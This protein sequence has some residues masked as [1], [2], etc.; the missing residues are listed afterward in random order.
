M[1]LQRITSP[2]Q[3]RKGVNP[4]AQ[5]QRQPAQ[6]NSSTNTIPPFGLVRVLKTTTDGQLLVD[7][8]NQD[9]QNVY[10]NGP[11]AILPNN[12]QGQGGG[13]VVTKATPLWAA[14][15]PSSGTPTPGASWGAKAGSYLLASGRSGFVILG[16]PV[17]DGKTYWRVLVDSVSNSTAAFVTVSASTPSTIY[18]G[19]S[20]KDAVLVAGSNV[21]QSATGGFTS[22]DV[23]ATLVSGP[24]GAPDGVIPTG[25]TI[26]SID[27][28]VTPPVAV[29]NNYAKADATGETVAIVTGTVQGYAAS[30][31]G[32]NNKTPAGIYDG[33]SGCWYYDINQFDLPGIFAGARYLCDQLATDAYGTAIYGGGHFYG[34]TGTDAIGNMFYHGTCVNVGGTTTAPAVIDGGSDWPPGT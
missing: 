32:W 28:T 13:G 5:V 16:Q 30:T 9:S 1:G 8:P 2:M 31:D 15:D 11:Q 10:L 14:Y 7:Q 19:R 21:L 17:T 6:N 33:V 23:G 22:A 34:A 26:T 29:M 25:T 12:G 4:Y 24:P 27:T 3:Q 18:L 20:I